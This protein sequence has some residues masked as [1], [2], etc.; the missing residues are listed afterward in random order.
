ML[1]FLN[2]LAAAHSQIS[3]DFFPYFSR[4]FTPNKSVSANTRAHSSERSQRAS[5][6]ATGNICR[7]SAKSRFARRALPT[8]GGRCRAVTRLL[9]SR[10]PRT[11]R[12][13]ACNSYCSSPLSRTKQITRKFEKIRRFGLRHFI[14]QINKCLIPKV[15]QLI[16]SSRH[17]YSNC[18]QQAL[19]HL[20]LNCC[21]RLE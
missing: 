16:F 7:A 3:H 8:T 5:N 11:H 12:D 1:T 14:R 2:D 19:D 13:I 18:N 4:R 9:V 20:A 17:E 10:A 15:C 21:G 6:E